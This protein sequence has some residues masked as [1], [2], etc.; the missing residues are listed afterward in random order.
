MIV[1]AC[2]C[3]LGGLVAFLTVR[4]ARPTD[5]VPRPLEQPCLDPSRLRPASAGAGSSGS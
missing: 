2:L 3:V 5:G 1:A 4:S